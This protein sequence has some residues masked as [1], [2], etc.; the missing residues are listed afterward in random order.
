MSVEARLE[1]CQTTLC[2]RGV[3]DVKFRFGAVSEKSLSQLSS[4]AADALEA[5]NKGEYET[6]AP[7]GDS[8]RPK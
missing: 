8:A 4:D 6:M 3:K 7:L 1:N 5:V 2:E